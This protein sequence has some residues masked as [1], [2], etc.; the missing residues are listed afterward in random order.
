M[1][2]PYG[3]VGTL[4]FTSK[5]LYYVAGTGYLGIALVSAF[6]TYLKDET[7]D[8]GS[9]VKDCGEYKGELSALT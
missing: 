7:K 3:V 6:S 8:F 2:R 4:V 9:I 1:D 5:F